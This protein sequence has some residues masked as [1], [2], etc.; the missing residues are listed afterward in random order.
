MNLVRPPEML[1]SLNDGAI[2][3]LALGLLFYTYNWMFGILITLSGAL[4]CLTPR[5]QSLMQLD[6]WLLDYTIW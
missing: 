5:L 4:G 2:G 3:R 6:V 1:A